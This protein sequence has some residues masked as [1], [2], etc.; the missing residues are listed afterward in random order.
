[1]FSNVEVD[2][3]EH[4]K[5]GINECNKYCTSIYE[6]MSTKYSKMFSFQKGIPTNKLNHQPLPN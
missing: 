3:G 6:C 1:M 2:V 5:K 4:Y